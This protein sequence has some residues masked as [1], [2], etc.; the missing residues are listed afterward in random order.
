M[1]KFLPGF[2]LL[3]LLTSCSSGAVVFA[4]TPLP[5]E[6]APTRYEHPSGAFTLLLPRTWSLYEQQTALF[7]AA[8]FAPP[9]GDTPLLSV[10]VLNVGQP[11]AA[12]AVGDW[13]LRYQEQFRPDLA[14][15]T[16][17][18]RQALDDGSWRVTGLRTTPNGHTQQVN[19]LVRAQGTLLGILD[20]T[21]PADAELRSR[22]QT[23]LN[24]FAFGAE[25]DLP[26][27]ELAV[28]SSA[29]AHPIEIT[30]V[31]TWT[32]PAGVFFVT[33]EIAN[34][35]AETMQGLSVR[36]QLLSEDGSPRADALDAV[37][38]YAVEAGGFAPF[39]IR[40]G[41]GQPLD[42]VRY[43]LS[44]NSEEATPHETLITAPALEW[45]AE[46]QFN[47][48]GALFVT[49]TVRNISREDVR[50]PR[51]IATIFDERGRVIAAGFAEADEAVLRASE[52]TTFAVLMSEL[53]GQPANFVVTVQALPC[54]EACED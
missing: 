10:R 33:G 16:E 7:A 9:E 32:S 35:S 1:M 20:I 45:S 11:I 25:F 27:S 30:N 4:P 5:P 51:A 28:L 17:Q 6:A 26:T 53:G 34:H 39:S 50:A 3:L 46:T 44:L 13:M 47:A 40:F 37:M 49:G 18:E 41:Q 43:T 38:G 23:I 52:E 2:L 24:T 19:T 48:E 8:S 54:D 12:D 15:Y 21:L 29:A 36:A 22:L 31:T 42:T 14:R